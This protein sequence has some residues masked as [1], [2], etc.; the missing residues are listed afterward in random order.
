MFQLA[1]GKGNFNTIW[2]LPGQDN[3]PETFAPISRE[4][5]DK[6]K[7]NQAKIDQKIKNERGLKTGN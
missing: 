5:W 3:E 1:G 4:W 7:A 6:I 2:P